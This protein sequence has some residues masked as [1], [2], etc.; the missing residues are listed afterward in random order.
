M[1]SSTLLH[2]MD[3]SLLPPLFSALL[4]LGFLFLCFDCAA[5]DS[6]VDIFSSGNLGTVLTNIP[7][8]KS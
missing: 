3:L 1:R 7:Q 2:K 6:R 5:G 4:V 8:V